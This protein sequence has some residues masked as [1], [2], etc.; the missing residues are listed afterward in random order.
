LFTLTSNLCPLEINGDGFA[1]IGTDRLFLRFTNKSGGFP[2]SSLF[3]VVRD[4]TK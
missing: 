1:E 3:I 4:E 2:L